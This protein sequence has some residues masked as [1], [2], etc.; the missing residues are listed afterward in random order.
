MLRKA[1]AEIDVYNDVDSDVVTWWRVLRDRTDELMRAIAL[2]PYSCEEFWAAHGKATGVD[3]IER[4]RRFYV[5]SVQGFGG[6]RGN[7]SVRRTGWR[8]TLA[9]TERRPAIGDEWHSDAGIDALYLAADRL[10]RVALEHADWQ[11][12]MHRYDSVDTLH[13]IDP[14]YVP[15][16]RS[17]GNEYSVEW[18]VDDHVN[19]LELVTSGRIKGMVVISGYDSEMYRQALVGWARYEVVNRANKSFRTEVL[20]VSPN[21]KARAQMALPGMEVAP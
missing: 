16:T 19:M 5:R 9:R 13:Y 10:R 20:W 12:V 11:V 8:R 18:S 1:P 4:A 17:Y 6:G 14:P 15:E 21:A 3:D 2:T 7:S